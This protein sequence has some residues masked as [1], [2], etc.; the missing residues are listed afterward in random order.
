VGSLPSFNESAG[1]AYSQGLRGP[2]ASVVSGDLEGG[3][4]CGAPG[5]TSTAGT[6]T[7]VRSHLVEVPTDDRSGGHRLGA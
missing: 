7:K 2:Y 4:Q 5:V 3:E 6:S 1:C